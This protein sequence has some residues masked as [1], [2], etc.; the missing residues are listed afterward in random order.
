[1]WVIHYSTRQTASEQT[2]ASMESK[3]FLFK[4]TWQYSPFIKS[5]IIKELFDC[6]CC[7]FNKNLLKAALSWS[8]Q[9]NRLW[10]CTNVSSSH[11]L[12]YDVCL[13]PL[14]KHKKNDCRSSYMCCSPQQPPDLHARDWPGIP[15]FPVH[16]G[17]SEG[18]VMSRKM[19]WSRTSIFLISGGLMFFFNCYYK[20]INIFFSIKLIELIKNVS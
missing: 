6:R 4:I 5:K 2:V 1:M 12:D 20:T 13:I 10:M 14:Q 8:W 18:S 17:K 11:Q 19:R 16:A 15:P 3:I 9:Q 7:D